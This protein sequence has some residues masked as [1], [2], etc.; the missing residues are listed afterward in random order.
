MLQAGVL[1]DWATSWLGAENVRSYRVRFKEQVWPGDTI[2]CSGSMVAQHEINGE[3]VIEVE[4]VCTRQ[5]GGVAVQGWASFVVPK[6]GVRD[7]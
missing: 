5:T 3:E 6:A 7:E 1:A 2:T 4:L